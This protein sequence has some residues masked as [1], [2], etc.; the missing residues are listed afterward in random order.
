MC[1]AARPVAMRPTDTQELLH[2]ARSGDRSAFDALY[3]LLYDELLEAARSRL[4]S[5]PG[6][7][8]LDTVGLVHEAY[9]RL[10][11]GSE[12]PWTDRAH[13]LAVAARAM[14]CA[15]VDHLR[16][17]SAQKRGGGDIH[18]TLSEHAAGAP[19]DPHTLL[20]ID[21]ALTRLAAF[22]DRLPRVA[23]C[24]LFGGLSEEET[25]EALNI[26]L[27]TAQRDWQRARAWLREALGA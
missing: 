26:S 22:N 25:A 24:R 11:Q 19:S 17:R 9:V 21:D 7:A 27:R 8:T 3:A 1:L 6:P 20:V 10:A 4:R 16:A 23:E 15:V 2:R 5:A 14:R 13:F 12:V 18:V